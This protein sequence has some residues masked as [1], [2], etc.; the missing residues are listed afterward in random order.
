MKRSMIVTAVACV[1]VSAG[2]YAG[3]AQAAPMAKAPRIPR[4]D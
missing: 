1:A 3:T 4:P 2:F